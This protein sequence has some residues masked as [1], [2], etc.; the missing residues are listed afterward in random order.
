[1]IK[2]GGVFIEQN[3]IFN[4]EDLRAL[5]ISKTK[6]NSYVLLFDDLYFEKIERNTIL[7]REVLEIF[8]RYVKPFEMIKY[9]VFKTE[10]TQS[11]KEI[12]QLVEE[13]RNY[14][15]I[16]ITIFNAKENECFLLF[17]GNKEDF[18]VENKIK[19]FS[20]VVK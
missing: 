7:T 15:K 8:R 3:I 2:K 6:E 12:K 18:E 9:I 1:M 16:I 10:N 13:L 17:T 20:K 19:E 14:T 5:L 4:F 11:T